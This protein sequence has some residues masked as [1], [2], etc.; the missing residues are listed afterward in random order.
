MLEY[1]LVLFVTLIDLRIKVSFDEAVKSD[2]S[3]AEARA[4]PLNL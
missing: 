2:V 1:Y 3:L 4:T